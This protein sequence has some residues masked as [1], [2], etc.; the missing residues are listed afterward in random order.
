MEGSDKFHAYAMYP[1]TRA[2]IT[3]NTKLNGPKSFWS[4]WQKEKSPSL[5]G[6]PEESQSI[7]TTELHS[8][9]VALNFTPIHKLGHER[10]LCSNY[11]QRSLIIYDYAWTRSKIVLP[12]SK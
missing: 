7:Y 1:H 9:T 6:H 10:V 12:E 2:L 8:S 3:W 11:R 4:W 5:P